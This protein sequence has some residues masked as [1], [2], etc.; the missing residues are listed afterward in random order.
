ME[1]VEGEPLSARIA[2]SPLLLQEAVDLTLEILSAVSAMHGR[3]LSP[4]AFATLSPLRPRVVKR[5]RQA[6]ESSGGAAL[7]K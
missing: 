3:S 5:A 2:C 1:F 7:V 4:Q 6:F